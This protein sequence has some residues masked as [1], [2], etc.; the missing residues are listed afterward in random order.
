VPIAHLFT[1]ADLTSAEIETLFCDHEDVKPSTC[2]GL[3][4]A[5]LPARVMARCSKKNV[6]PYSLHFEAGM[7]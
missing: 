7:N 1:V 2:K 5:L 3:R 6:A 4:E